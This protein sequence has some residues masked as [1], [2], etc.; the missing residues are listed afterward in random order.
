MR[1]SIL[2]FGGPL[3]ATKY[4]NVKLRPVRTEISKMPCCAWAA[5]SYLAFGKPLIT[6]ADLVKIQQGL[7]LA[8]RFVQDDGT[9]V[10]FDSEHYGAVFRLYGCMLS[11]AALES[12]PDFLGS[13]L[14]RQAR[15]PGAKFLLRV[16]VSLS[17]SH[18]IAVEIQSDGRVLLVDQWTSCFLEQMR[19]NARF[20][21]W[22]YTE[23]FELRRVLPVCEHPAA[24]AGALARIALD[25][26]ACARRAA[27][28][29]AVNLQRLRTVRERGFSSASIGSA[30]KRWASV[31][32]RHKFLRLRVARARREAL[33]TLRRAEF[34]GA[35]FEPR[36]RARGMLRLAGARETRSARALQALAL[37]HA[38]TARALEPRCAAW[39]RA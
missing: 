28:D 23:D 5:I 10:G 19:D 39:A 30:Y 6:P 22:Y 12:E 33:E 26:D 24:R 2:P 17:V 37:D 21:R 3:R 4:E 38:R 1:K 18:A 32:T 35:V 11:E 13:Y 16:R 9:L 25:A 8:S 20:G 14:R 36:R 7:P 15:T 29:L 27:H 31:Y 34:A